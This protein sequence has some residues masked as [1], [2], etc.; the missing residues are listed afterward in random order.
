MQRA[1]EWFASKEV[2]YDI[3]FYSVDCSDYTVRTGWR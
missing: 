2:A 3:V 1:A